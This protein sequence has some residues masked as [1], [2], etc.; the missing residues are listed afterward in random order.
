[1]MRSLIKHRKFIEREI[2]DKNTATVYNGV[3]RDARWKRAYNYAVR[4]KY[5]PW[6]HRIYKGG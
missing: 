3:N 4:Y 1:M 2:F 5:M 6:V